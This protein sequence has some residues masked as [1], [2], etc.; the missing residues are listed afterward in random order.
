M[1][2]DGATLRRGSHRGCQENSPGT[3]MQGL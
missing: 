1:Q 2:K 3:G